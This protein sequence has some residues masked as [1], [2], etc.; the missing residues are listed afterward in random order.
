MNLGIYS[1]KCEK[2]ISENKSKWEKKYPTC[3]YFF[4]SNCQDSNLYW[5]LEGQSILRIV[6]NCR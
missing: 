6:I 5:V 2:D 1:E 3:F 4:I